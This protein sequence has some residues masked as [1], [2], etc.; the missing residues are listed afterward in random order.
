MNKTSLSQ[1][2]QTLTA[3]QTLSA[4]AMVDADTAVRAASGRVVPHERDELAAVL[5]GSSAHAD[6]VQFLRA[7]EPASAELAHSLAHGAAVHEGRERS[8]RGAHG[9]RQRERG[10]QWG[11]VAACFIAACALFVARQDNHTTIAEAKLAQQAAPAAVDTIFDAGMEQQIAH[12]SGGGGDVIFRDDLMGDR[13]F[14]SRTD[15]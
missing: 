9:R 3:P 7:L 14:R 15:G 10:W 2:Y 8:R 1:L 6:L 5:A 12:Q 13:L 11:A 4:R